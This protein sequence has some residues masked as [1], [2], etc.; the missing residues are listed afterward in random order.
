[1]GNVTF[2]DL[3]DDA[4]VTSDENGVSAVR[5]FIVEGLSGA[6]SGRLFE[7]LNTPGIPVK[8]QTHPN[9][10]GIVVKSVQA[11]PISGCNTKAFVVVSYSA[12]T[13]NSQTPSESATPTYRMSGVVQDEETSEDVNGDQV[14][15]NH[16]KT[17]VVNGNNVDTPLEPQPA[18]MIVQRPM[19]YFSCDRPEPL[20]F[21][22]LKV[23]NF[24]GR[25]NSVPWRNFPARTVL[26]TTIDVVESGDR[27]N[28]SY[29]F[30]IKPIGTWRART[31]YTDP[32]TGAPVKDPVEG[33]GIKNVL[34]YPEADF[35]QLNV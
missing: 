33:V 20:P 26:C 34:V 19:Q 11:V 14:V 6:G 2:T 27:A 4:S 32:S 10:A 21:N 9:L 28:V 18:K 22:Y 16:T 13:F 29:Q 23:H 15:L 12:P 7:A 24:V 8:G 17:S 30:T 35:N 31:V 25:I 5:K 1:M 3:I